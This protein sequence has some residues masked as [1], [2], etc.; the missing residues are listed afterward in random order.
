MT[1]TL[2]E[3]FLANRSKKPVLIFCKQGRKA[4]SDWLYGTLP[5]KYIFENME[6]LLL[7]LEKVDNGE[8]TDTS[9]W[10]FFD[11]NKIITDQQTNQ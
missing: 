7:C 1:G 11:W 10:H 5:Q 3:I 4:V 2:E 9:R 6:D 8:E